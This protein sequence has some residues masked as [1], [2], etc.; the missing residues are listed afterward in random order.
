MAPSRPT[1]HKAN[2]IVLFPAHAKLQQSSEANH[3]LSR[4]FDQDAEFL[5]APVAVKVT[6]DE[7]LDCDEDIGWPESAS[8]LAAASETMKALRAKF[9]CKINQRVAG[10]ERAAKP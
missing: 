4:S 8:A 6:I 9:C 5:A 10:F 7:L 3:L 1:Q 2:L